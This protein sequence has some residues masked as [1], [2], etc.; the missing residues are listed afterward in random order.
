MRGL[1]T[2]EM[3]FK[4]AQTNMLA[5]LEWF[6]TRNEVQELFSPTIETA[7]GH[8]VWKRDFS[9]ANGV[10]G[11]LFDEQY[12]SETMGLFV[13][14][15]KL[16]PVGS[17]WGGYESLIIYADPSHYRTATKW[18]NT[19]PLIRLHIG[20]ESTDDLIEDLSAG[21]GRLNLAK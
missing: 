13:D 3:R 11:V 18:D 10:F 12:S 1:R 15:L 20:L 21:F 14:S 6:K 19:N 16:F 2:V 8:D 9:G 17:S 5:V 7:R 4:Q